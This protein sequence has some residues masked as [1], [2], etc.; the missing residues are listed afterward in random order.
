MT[1]LYCEQALTPEGW[2]KA[3]RLRLTAGR[4]AAIEREVA[5]QPGDERHAV[6]VPAMPNL[7]SHAF[8]RGMAGLAEAPGPVEDNFW[9][10]RT[11]MYRFASRMSPHHLQAIAA[12]AYVEMLEAGYC[13]VGEFHYVHHDVDGRRFSDAGEMAG[14]IAAAAS[15]TGISLTLLPVFYAHS[16][17]GGKPPTSGQ[18]RFVHDLQSYGRLIERCIELVRPLPA[19]VVGVAPHSLRAVT[20]EELAEIVRLLP[21]APVHIHIAEQTNEIRDCLT[22]SG[23]RPVRWLFE[24][25]EVDSRWCL[26]HAT[27]VDDSEL[28]SLARSSA[29]VGLCPITEANLGDGIFPAAQF[30]AAG[31]EFGVGTDSNVCITLSGELSL[32]EY[33]QRLSNRSRNVI[34]LEGHS[35]GAALYQ[36]ALRGAG[37]A[38]GA[39][40]V[41][42]AIG[43]PADLVS[44]ATHEPAM[45]CRSGDALI[46][47]WLF[48]TTG[49]VVDCVWVNGVKQVEAGR[50]RLRDR[51][52]A[53]HARAIEELCG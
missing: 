15:E 19:G 2:I 17:F 25:V 40:S 31:G 27:H 52:R 29:T 53:A 9:G 38:L 5:P 23:M 14:R 16:S 24:H 47:S 6:I 7:H 22:W 46:D 26:V 10:W 1:I 18:A 33:T 21:D 12:Q 49:G 41:G 32:L 36:R 34:G 11:T 51:V 45:L 48:A 43:A 35:T 13:R 28:A 42:I 30:V 20:P 50:H 37:Q 3:A 4:I 39:P 8:Q 44:L